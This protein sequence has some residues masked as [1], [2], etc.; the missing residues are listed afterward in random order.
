MRNSHLDKHLDL[1]SKLSEC[2]RCKLV[3]VTSWLLSGLGYEY[4]INSAITKSINSVFFYETCENSKFLIKI[5]VHDK[6]QN[7]SIS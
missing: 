5:L 4:H 3:K 1:C 6:A 2:K 7:E